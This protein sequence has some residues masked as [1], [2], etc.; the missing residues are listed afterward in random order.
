MLNI[1]HNI[2]GML[3]IWHNI[4]G[5]LN[6]WHNIQAMLNIWH[7][8]Q[9]I[10]NIWFQMS[11]SPSVDCH[12]STSRPLDPVLSQLT[13]PSIFETY[14]TYLHLKRS[15]IQP[16]PG[17]FLRGFPKKCCKHLLFLTRELYLIGQIFCV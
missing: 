15:L 9:E 3:N 4:Q 11:G 8:I 13:P 6:I 14:F 10:L 7:N 2:Q 1:W 12:V 17:P 16:T 5:I